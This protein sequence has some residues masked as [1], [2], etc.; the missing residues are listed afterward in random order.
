V[1]VDARPRPLGVRVEVSLTVEQRRALWVLQEYDLTPLAN[2]LRGDGSLPPTWV[3][4][5]ILEFRRYLGLQVIAPGPRTM[6]S[7]HVDRVWH[8]CLLFSRLYADLCQQVFGQFFHH[9]PAGAPDP[10]RDVKLQE[11]LQLY[12]RVYGPPGRLWERP[13]HGRT[14]TSARPVPR[15][16]ASV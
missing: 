1:T 3:D 9:D 8:A 2:R 5:A 12:E 10:A 14:S 4:E 11:F 6:F 16:G 13:A 15:P 7:S